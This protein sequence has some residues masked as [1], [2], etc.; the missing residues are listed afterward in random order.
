VALLDLNRLRS[1]QIARNA[2]WMMTGQGISLVVQATYFVLLARLLG[3]TEYG[4]F[5]GASALGFI[6]S[7]YCDLGSG[8][9]FLRHVSPSHE[10]FGEFWG[11]ILISNFGAGGLVVIL[12]VATARWTVGS[13]PALLVFLTAVSNCIGLPI[14]T[15]AGQVF[16]TF[17]QMR[18]TALLNF[19]QNGLRLILAAC[20]LGMLHRASALQWGWAALAVSIVGIV[21]SIVMVHR[22]FGPPKLSIRIWYRTIREGFGFS[23]AGSTSSAYNDLDKAMLSHYGMNAANGTY[24]VAYRVVNIASTPAFAIYSAAYP[25]FFRKGLDGIRSTVTYGWKVLNNALLVTAPV[26]LGMF[27][28]A[29][30]LPR[31]AGPGFNEATFAL[32]WLCL[33]PLFRSFHIAAGYAMTS[34]GYQ[35]FRTASQFGAAMF[36]WI[37]NIYLI[38]R[39]SWRGAAWS[40]LATDGGLAISNWLILLWLV[41][42]R[43]HTSAL[44]GSRSTSRTG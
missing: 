41:R 37:L 12:C 27:L 18:Y 44:K 26:C 17:E 25:T 33:I 32:R 10:K 28:L 5:A 16:Q 3:S 22:K 35:R 20:M 8:M 9:L 34:A 39:H 14:S 43:P 11:N 1:S 23:F 15:C 24:S 42:T 29:P 40:S 4:V 21:T 7:P 36:N 6:V 38:P 19:I 13:V 31:F 2:G 30:M